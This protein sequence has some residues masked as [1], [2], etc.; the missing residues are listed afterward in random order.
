LMPRKAGTYHP[1][2]HVGLA[3]R[4]GGGVR[5]GTD[6]R[7]FVEKWRASGGAERANYQLLLAEL[8]RRCTPN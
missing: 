8:C 1:P 4:V 3:P 7:V 2:K 6:V 5:M